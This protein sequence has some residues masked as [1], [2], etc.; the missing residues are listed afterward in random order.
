MISFSFD[1]LFFQG[2]ARG[3]AAA[4]SHTGLSALGAGFHRGFLLFA[5]GGKQTKKRQGAFGA[6]PLLLPASDP[7]KRARGNMRRLPKPTAH[8]HHHTITAFVEVH[9]SIPFPANFQIEW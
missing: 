6:L 5:S 3:S 1:G 2:T 7:K 8:A 4:H 9:D